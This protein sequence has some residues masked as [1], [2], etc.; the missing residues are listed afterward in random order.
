MTPILPVAPVTGGATTHRGSSGELPIAH[1]AILSAP[2]RLAD[3]PRPL[4][5]LATPVATGQDGI[6]QLRTALGD[7]FVRPSA[8]LPL[9]RPL[10]LQIASGAPAE[11][12]TL[13]LASGAAEN[14]ADLIQ[15]LKESAQAPAPASAVPVR[16]GMASPGL[17]FT[18]ALPGSA[19]ATAAA[20]TGGLVTPDALSATVAA[21][22]SAPAPSQ[23]EPMTISARPRETPA[24]AQPRHLFAESARQPFSGPAP[25]QVNVQ[26]V[27]VDAES[28]LPGSNAEQPNRAL[29]AVVIGATTQN[30]PIIATPLGLLIMERPVTVVVGQKLTLVVADRYV[31]GGA[32]MLPVEYAPEGEWPSLTEAVR[33]LGQ[34]DVP[35][36][37]QLQAMMPKPGA[38]LAPALALFLNLLRGPRATDWPGDRLLD[39]LRVEGRGDVADAIT[40]DVKWAADQAAQPNSAGWRYYAIPLLDGGEIA[41]LQLAVRNDPDDSDSAPDSEK[42][43]GSTRFVVDVTPSRLGPVQLDGLLAA[44]RLDMV[45]RFRRP[46][47]IQT[48]AQIKEI[49]SLSLENAGLKGAISVQT[50]S[51]GWTLIAPQRTHVGVVA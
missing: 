51:G 13:S 20:P 3:A 30:R 37:A 48:I 8:P 31:P 25:Q 23:S 40:G 22:T 36:S 29:N 18:N 44:K 32:Q 2:D 4:T 7:L 12:V 49:F 39:A 45:V 1:A 35:A 47:S 43:G 14:A 33:S 19:A 17:L 50:A 34:A 27:A 46:L 24:G 41:R 26:V 15:P 16:A 28:P 21:D 38:Q 9:G 11:Q 5:L 6:V 42:Q 10:T